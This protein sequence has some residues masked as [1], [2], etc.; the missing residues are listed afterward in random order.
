MSNEV[1][2]K[3]YWIGVVED[4]GV[5]FFTLPLPILGWQAYYY[6]RHGIWQ[7]LSFIDALRYVNMKWAISPSD[8]IGLYHF[9]DWIPL[10]LLLLITGVSLAFVALSQER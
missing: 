6:L 10:S 3:P 5:F 2:I 8:W 9:L 1:N 7:P 4:I